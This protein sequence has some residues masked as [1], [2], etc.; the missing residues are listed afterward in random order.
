MPPKKNLIADRMVADPAASYFQ[1]TDAQTLE[2]SGVQASERPVT[3]KKDRAKLTIY[4]PKEVDVRL[5]ELQLG[6][7][8]ET[9][10]KPE[11]SALVAEAITL[12]VNQ[13]SKA[14]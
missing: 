1:K 8:R 5:R 6:R 10:T 12:L 7:L 14:S 3:E 4:V 11:L 9:G 2:R 13:A